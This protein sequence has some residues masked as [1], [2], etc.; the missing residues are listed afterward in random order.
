MKTTAVA[1]D[2]LAGLVSGERHQAPGYLGIGVV[3]AAEAAKRHD[4]YR[5]RAADDRRRGHA[6]RGPPG[7]RHR[8]RHRHQGLLRRLDVQRRVLLAN[9]LP[10]RPQLAARLEPELSDKQIARRLIRGQGVGL[11][12][13]AIEGED[14]LSRD[15]LTRRTGGQQ[16][17]QLGDQRDVPTTGEIGVDTSFQRDQPL[18]LQAGDRLLG[19]R[20]EDQLGECRSAPQVQR[21]AQHGGRA[22]GLPGG[23]RVAAVGH[24]R[25]EALGIELS[26]LDP[27]AVPGRG[28]GDDVPGTE[29][30]AQPRDVH[31]H[32]LD[33]SA[34]RLLPP[35]RER[36]PLGAH[37]LIGTQQQQRENRAWFD[38]AKRHD[39]TIV[40]DLKWPKN[41]EFH[42]GGADGIGVRSANPTRSHLDHRRNPVHEVDRSPEGLQSTQVQIIAASRSAALPRSAHLH[43]VH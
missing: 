14:Q 5:D 34:R 38:P 43:A 1:H 29:R 33:R 26:R 21:L 6:R 30:L 31:L 23:E 8:G 4:Q 10:Q 9:E 13:A 22:L 18:F 32:G 42:A 37:R 15:S 17:L 7:I 11:A 39:A 19:E 27:Q 25:V 2:D 28:R 20:L 36:E 35:Q 24:Q 41:S 40:G 3:G 12:P 16:L